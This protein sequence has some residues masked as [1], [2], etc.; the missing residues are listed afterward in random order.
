M[1]E[2][3][4]GLIK[5]LVVDDDQTSLRIME[6]MIKK[7]GCVGAYAQ[8]GN[9]AIELVKNYRFDLCF[10]DVMMPEMGGVEA[11]S[12]IKENYDAK[13]PIIAITSSNMK[14]TKEI[15]TEVGMDDFITKPVTFDIIKDMIAKYAV[16]S[17]E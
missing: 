9:Q 4:W 5:V 10:M 16:K 8:N 12:V 13:L 15:C 14:A 17:A 6:A 3:Y 7:I 11:T 1:S 2:I